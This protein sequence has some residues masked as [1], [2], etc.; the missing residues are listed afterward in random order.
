MRRCFVLFYISSLSSAASLVVKARRGVV[1]QG[2]ALLS[3][4]LLPVS[5]A[6]AEPGFKRPPVTQF[7]AA[8]GDPG[9]NSGSGA[10]TWGLWRED[11]G[12]R[13]VFLKSYES[14]LAATGG[15][16]PAGWTFDPS[17]WWLEEHGLIME[18][19]EPLPAR[20]L[21]RDGARMQLVA[22]E[23]KYLVTGGRETT[24]I[25][26]VHDDGRWDLSKGKLFDVT[27]LPCRSARYTATGT[28]GG[29]P[30]SPTRANQKDFPVAPGAKMPGVAGC[31]AT[32]YAVLFVI[33]IEA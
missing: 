5:R 21:A 17:G 18:Q 11:P 9:A 31:A 26:T 25:L 24:A 30:C 14:K 3:A 16:A 33:G 2:A 20:K 15:K 4:S 29:A 23:A 19:P 10:D 32:D 8:L 7:I 28:P 22:P 1:A 6:A 12:P 27:H 13:G